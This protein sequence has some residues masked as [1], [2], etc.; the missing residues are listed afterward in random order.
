MKKHKNKGEKIFQV[1]GKKFVACPR[2]NS[3]LEGLK[4]TKRAFPGTKIKVRAP[5]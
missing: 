3:P 4:A 1:T 2:H 5:E